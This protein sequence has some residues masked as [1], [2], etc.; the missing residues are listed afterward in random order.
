[1]HIIID[2]LPNFKGRCNRRDELTE[3]CEHAGD[4]S[5]NH[6]RYE[7]ASL[8]NVYLYF[9]FTFTAKERPQ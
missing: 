5:F 1:M 8:G 2:S 7:C 6:E 9:G 4:L 3:R